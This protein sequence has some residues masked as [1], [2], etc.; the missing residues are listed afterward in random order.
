MMRSWAIAAA[1]LLLTG[2]DSTTVTAAKDAETQARMVERNGGSTAEQCTAK[3][4]VADAWLKALDESKYRS[5]KTDADLTCNRAAL[6][7]MRL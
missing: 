7:S 5:A 2:C 3:K 1:A 6:E 4:A